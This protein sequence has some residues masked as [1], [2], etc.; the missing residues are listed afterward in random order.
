MLRTLLGW[1]VE[2]ENDDEPRGMMPAA[3]R[4]SARTRRLKRSPS[5]GMVAARGG[6]RCRKVEGRLW[7][8][9]A[10]LRDTEGEIQGGIGC[11]GLLGI[12]STPRE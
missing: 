4:R 3:V 6:E 12:D 5:D 11:F 1:A 7:G 10:Q 8:S 2:F 9:T